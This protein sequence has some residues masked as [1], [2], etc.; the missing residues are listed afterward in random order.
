VPQHT[1]TWR[2]RYE[3]L[4]AACAIVGIVELPGGVNVEESAEARPILL[5]A[6][7]RSLAAMRIAELEPE[8]TL[9]D[10]QLAA[11]LTLLVAADAS[12]VVQ[13][14][15]TDDDAAQLVLVEAGPVACVIEYEAPDGCVTIAHGSATAMRARILRRA[16]VELPA[17]VR[18]AKQGTREQGEPGRWERL[19]DGGA[20]RRADGPLTARAA[21]AAVR[22]IA[23]LAWLAAGPAGSAVGEAMTWI[24]DDQGVVTIELGEPADDD[25]VELGTTFVSGSPWPGAIDAKWPAAQR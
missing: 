2:L 5:D 7:L 24:V 6:G 8:P 25:E 14:W 11:A 21:G 19:V 16:D 3:Q 23:Q 15:C 9:V 1:V 20:V 10:A 12:L 4:V 18:S 22:G 13:L 17:G